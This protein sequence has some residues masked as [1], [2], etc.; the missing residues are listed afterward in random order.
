MSYNGNFL[1]ILLGPTG[2]GKTDLSISIAK[3][4]EAPIIS[5][6][7]RQFYQEMRIGT[8]A[9][10]PSQLAGANHFFIGNKSITERYSCGM[11]EVDAL[12]LLETVFT[13]SRIA[14][15]VG[16]SGL[17]IDAVVNGIDDFPTPDPEL[18]Q[19]LLSQ[20]KNEGVASL[21]A[22]LKILDP[23]YYGKV[24]LRNSQRVLKA[25]E[26]CLQTGLTY[27]SF[28]THR[29]KPRFFNSIFVGL[30]RPREELY[31]LIN[32]RVESMM[33]EGLLDEAK[34][35]YPFR[36]LNALN[37]VG[38]RELFSYLDGQTS[39]E[40]AIELIKRNTR[41]YA[42]RQLS[43]WSRNKNITWFHPSQLTEITEFIEK[44]I[45]SYSAK[46]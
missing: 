10:T 5:A 22:Q 42:K 25:L 15:L 3:H 32:Q 19:A 39:L 34:K 44:T 36:E 13:S 33:A 37:T 4:F 27:T 12:N 45:A 1:V 38:Y 31:R 8:A 2:V 21:R 29:A 43:W 7:S 41:R 18:R 46:N 24:D 35:L 28:L 9:P 14:L 26:G 11:F 6:D 17:Y 20:L 30:N 16:G 40:E 23:E